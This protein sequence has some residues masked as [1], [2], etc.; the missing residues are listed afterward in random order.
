MSEFLVQNNLKMFSTLERVRKQNG[1]NFD[2]YYQFYKSNFNQ[3]FR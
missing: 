2:V 1:K 3:T